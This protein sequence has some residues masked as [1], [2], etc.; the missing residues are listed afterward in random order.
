MLLGAVTDAAVKV[1]SLNVTLG[2]SVY[3]VDVAKVGSIGHP[4]LI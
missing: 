1:W 3:L 2:S 4:G